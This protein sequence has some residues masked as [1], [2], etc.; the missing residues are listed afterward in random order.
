MRKI[1]SILHLIYGLLLFFGV[2]FCVLPF[3]ILSSFIPGRLG[4]AIPF[5]FLRVWAF[6]FS[7]LSLFI[8][9]IYDRK[10]LDP[11]GTYIYVSNHNSYLDSPAVVLATP[12]TFKPLG[13]V[14]MTKIPFFGFIYQRVVVLIDRSSK[15]SRNAS[16]EKLKEV[17]QQGTSILIFPEGTMNTTTEPVKDF[18]DGA[19]RIAI[20]TQTPLAPFVV[21]N[22]RT[23]LPRKNPLAIKPGIIKV[24]FAPAID[25][26]G[27][28]LDD[29]EKL[30][31]RV[32]L[33]LKELIELHQK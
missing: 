31:E 12:N 7:T 11:Q 13:K 30:R 1:L 24:F 5:F 27:Y 3:I 32:R 8:I 10:V 17:I 26:S 18:Y 20:E 2:M 16:V 4:S 25:V 6:V 29:V 28:T 22:A 9:R 33:V 19:F 15:E 14:E 23:L 21:I